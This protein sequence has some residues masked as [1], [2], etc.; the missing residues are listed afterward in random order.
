MVLIYKSLILIV[1]PLVCSRSFYG[2]V[3]GSH[4]GLWLFAGVFDMVHGPYYGPHLFA[5]MFMIWYMV[6]TMVLGCLQQC[7]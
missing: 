1:V 6:L 7:L 4:Y 5:G 2:V 3:H